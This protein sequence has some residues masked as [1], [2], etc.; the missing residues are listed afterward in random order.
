MKTN[1]HNPLSRFL[2]LGL[3]ILLLPSCSGPAPLPQKVRHT[4]FFA[5]VFTP[6]AVS[7]IYVTRE[8][9]GTVWGTGWE[10]FTP[11][12]HARVEKDVFSL[13]I[14][15]LATGEERIQR[16]WPP[17]PL[18]GREIRTYRNRTFSVPRVYLRYAD[19]G[20]LEY[21]VSISIPTQPSST[22]WTISRTADGRGSDEWTVKS[23][24]FSGYRM[25]RL[26]G[27]R[28]VL[29]VPG[30]E[31]FPAAVLLVDHTDSTQSV[32]ADGPAF[33]R[34]YPEG[35]PARIVA[36]GSQK[37]EIERLRRMKEA[38]ERILQ[39]FLDEGVPDGKA[40]LLTIR[41]MQRLGYYPKPTTITATR[42]TGS[43]TATE[44]EG[45][46]LFS[47]SEMEFRVGLFQD[48]AAAIASPGT[49][50]EKSM[51]QYIRHRDYDTSGRI[52]AF[53][54][55]GGTVFRV[56]FSGEVFELAIKRPGGEN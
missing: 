32:L 52:N 35:V 8:T 10:H 42:L 27:S 33:R 11:P 37:K 34:L 14:R 46:P 2:S 43:G 47:I 23:P 26:R 12:A 6:D 24:V 54:K 28:E 21:E 39:G 1:E 55:G 3:L 7:V 38:H 15:D 49:P 44:R 31:A 53:L 51:G 18:E 40:R 4:G 45:P 56:A 19:D 48:I 16:E 5:P 9:E 17:S 13:R 29:T 20:S 50:T 36:E 41:E 22:V 25:D 30:E